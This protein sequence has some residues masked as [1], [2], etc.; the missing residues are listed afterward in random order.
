MF[1]GKRGTGDVSH[2]AYLVV[3][4]LILVASVFLALMGYVKSLEENTLFE[5]SYL[6][7]DL[8][9]L[10]NTI[11]ASPSQVSYV[12]SAKFDLSRF[13]FVF[14]DSAVTVY[15]VFGSASNSFGSADSRN[16]KGAK[17]YYPFGSDA[18]IKFGAPTIS[19]PNALLFSFADSSVTISSGDIVSSLF[20]PEVVTKDS[21]A[22][23]VVIDPGHGI[24]TRFGPSGTGLGA[25]LADP[26]TGVREQDLVKAIAVSL[27]GVLQ[28]DGYETGL[29]RQNDDYVSMQDRLAI[30]SA[31]DVSIVISIHVSKGPS[32]TARA[33]I[34][35]NSAS[36]IKS[37]KLACFILKELSLKF[38]NITKAEIV[39]L[40]S[41]DLIDGSP[42]SILNSKKVSVLLEIGSIGLRSGILSRSSIEIAVPIKEAVKKYYE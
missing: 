39:F 9:L 19:N 15:E 29:A 20:C 12:Y 16:I 25:G 36:S 35:S 21:S 24:D 14:Q 3:F 41:G 7:K 6:S 30:A 1:A 4:E 5:K 23:K 8:A 37:E 26:S 17:I 28:Q 13:N 42:F 32:D 18:N 38:R 2:H 33:Y 31:D 22:H 40:D 27:S 34:F 10:M 11:Y